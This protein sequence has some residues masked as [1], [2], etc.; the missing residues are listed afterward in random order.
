[1]TTELLT[2]ISAVLYLLVSCAVVWYYRYRASRAQ[3]ALKS[4]VNAEAAAQDTEDRARVTELETAEAD[5]QTAAFNAAVKEA[6]NVDD[7]EGR[8]REHGAFDRLRR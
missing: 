4:H 2:K 5:R 1:M 6:K 8:A 7:T 3:E